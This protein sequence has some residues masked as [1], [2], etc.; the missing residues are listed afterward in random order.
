MRQRALEQSTASQRIRGRVAVPL[1]CS[2]GRASTAGLLAAVAD[3]APGSRSVG[4]RGTDIPVISPAGTAA[5]T[6]DVVVLT[7]AE[8]LPRGVCP[9]A[10][11]AGRWV[12][13]DW[14]ATQTGPRPSAPG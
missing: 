8:R 5:A 11:T 2:P 6:P 10:R 13:D 9:A 4:C 12:T 3:A 14:I 1:R 7:L